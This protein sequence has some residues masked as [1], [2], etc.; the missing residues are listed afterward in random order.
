MRA[1]IMGAAALALS[2]ATSAAAVEMRS[3][4]DIDVTG[5]FSEMLLIAGEDVTI[6]VTATDDAF[7]AG[8]DV[9]AK[10]AS[11]DHAYLAGADVT[12]QDSNAHDLFVAGGDVD[13]LSGHIADD[14]AGAGGHISLSREAHIDGDAVIAGGNLE[15]KSPIGGDLR[16][17]G[18]TIELNSDVTGDVFLDGGTI[19]IGPEAHIHGALTHRGRHV[20][21]SPQ[22]QID[23]QTNA[24]RAR[25]EPNLQPLREILGWAGVTLTLGLVLM[26]IVAAMA[27][28]GLM[29]RASLMTMQYPVR[30]LAFGFLVAFFGPVLI[31]ILMVT[32][33][34]LPLA[35]L[36]SAL[37]LVLWPLGLTASA[38]ALGMLV[39]ERSHRGEGDPTLGARALWTG[40]AMAIIV[41]LG[42]VPV[43]GAFVWVGAY[44][45]GIGALTAQSGNLVR[46]QPAAA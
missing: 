12:F 29:N 37:M 13:V 10:N 43:L 9:T 33:L 25:P 28:P 14:F 27:F 16:A 2:W 22:A 46:T 19:I 30:S 39:R 44:L 1:L 3:G 17:G 41:A 15:I 42:Y 32:V 6:G 5:S 38:Y 35:L 7:G 23:G 34:G 45:V 11:F 40:I 18:G 21:I 36:L 20:T 4:E 26:A 31:I 8:G 24:L